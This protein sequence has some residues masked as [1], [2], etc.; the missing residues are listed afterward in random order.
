MAT[1]VQSKKI[2]VSGGVSQA[3]TFDNTVTTGN[4]I[5]VEV[6]SWGNQANGCSD[7]KSN[8]YS[9]QAAAQS[10]SV[11]SY[12]RIY[13][14]TASTAGSSFQVTV[15]WPGASDATVIIAE[16]SG[17]GSIECANSANG[18]GTSVSV[19][20]NGA[21]TSA[22]DTL[23]G[24]MAHDADGT[25]ALTEGYTLIEEAEDNHNSAAGN[26]QYRNLS[27][28]GT[29]S[30][31]WTIDTSA[32]WNASLIA[33]K[34]PTTPVPNA[35]TLNSASGGNTQVALSWTPPSSGSTPSGYKVRRGTSTG[36]YGT[37]I[38]VG[39]VTAYT[40]TGL[41]NGTQYF[42]VI[43]GYNASG[44]GANS[45]ELN[46]T[47][48]TGTPSAPTL[49]TAT[50]GNAQV[51]LTW[52]S[53]AGA[54]GYKIKYGTST[55]SHPTTIDVS[56]VTSYL[57]S[58]IGNGTPY[59]FV[60]VAYNASGDSAD[61]NELSATPQSG[62]TPNAPVFNSLVGTT[63]QL[64]ATW[65]V[66]PNAT[67]YKVKRGTTSGVYTTTTDVGN[68]TT[69]NITGLTNGTR[70]FVAVTA[71]NGVGDGGTSNEL[72][73]QPAATSFIKSKYND[74]ASGDILLFEQL[75]EIEAM[76]AGTHP[77]PDSGKI[78]KSVTVNGVNGYE[79]AVTRNVDGTGKN[80]WPA[81][82]AYVNTGQAGSGFIDQYSYTSVS[83]RPFEFICDGTTQLDPMGVDFTVLTG[84]SS[85]MYFGVANTKWDGL[86]LNITTP[87]VYTTATI[88]YEYWNGA[89]VTLTST[90][91]ATNASNV[92]VTADLKTVSRHSVV[93]TA[94]SDW[95]TTTIVGQAAYWIR[96]RVSAASG[97]T[98]NP[99]HGG[100]KWATRGKRQYG[101]SIAFM[102]RNSSTW[103]DF[104][105]RAT[106]GNLEGYYDYGTA[107][108]GIAAG[109]YTGAWLAADEINGIR[110]MQG[111]NQKGIIR[112][113]GTWTFTGNGSQYIDWNNTTLTVAG[114]INIIGG[115][116]WSNLTGLSGAI[117]TAGTTATWSGVSSIPSRI[118]YDTTPTGSGLFLSSTG[119]GFYN[120]S[121][122]RTYM[123]ASGQFFF[124]GAGGA[125]L[126]WD[127][128]ALAGYDNTP[129]LQWS[130]DATTGAIKAGGGKVRIDA[131][132]ITTI[133]TG[134]TIV[135]KAFIQFRDYADTS[136]A[137]SIG[138]VSYFGAPA[139]ATRMEL[140][141]PG[142]YLDG[143]NAYITIGV[144]TTTIGLNGTIV[145]IS[146]DASIGGN[147]TTYGDVSLKSGTLQVTNAVGVLRSPINTTTKA[148][149]V[150][151]G[152]SA[153]G[154]NAGFTAA[155]RDFTG[156][157]V[158][159]ANG[160]TWWVYGNGA[161]RIAVDG[162]GVA[163]KSSPGT[164]WANLSDARVKEVD[165][166][167]K[168]GLA[169]ILKVRPVVFRYNGKGG[170]IND[171]KRNVGV[172]AQEIREVFPATVFDA[173][174]LAADD[175]IKDLLAF[176]SSE[177]MWA[178]VNAIKELSGEVERL[179]IKTL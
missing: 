67:G 61:S 125:S 134:D 52:T 24:V 82:S 13:T 152:I 112:T 124:Y 138:F 175:E 105:A 26:A 165:A 73:A 9:P 22:T 107:A 158:M 121:A 3:L 93:F 151:G 156:D 21:T 19:S 118:A 90:V 108:Y 153:E 95:A 85:A 18:T 172:I 92:A 76:T 36:S 46:A 155:S 150:N 74:I 77:S 8:T 62:N 71:Y 60:A 63:T 139:G 111:T 23:T 30:L 109:D 44:D 89:W 160:N 161:N 88:V 1:K 163:Y 87:A 106:V 116:G 25:H 59:F 173:D 144:G 41:S 103:N 149:A 145:G 98:Q 65:S 148:L 83:S 114:T 81:G 17:V 126:Q 91:S 99:K 137:A 178:L 66:V 169:E 143:T 14:A 50:A 130:T 68:V 34:P 120:G 20:T 72:N 51:A 69:Y 58:G 15:T 157:W 39:N 49:S 35:P 32:N 122:W 166:P 101:S 131:N 12:S 48:A 133:A 28:T 54:T 179:K 6:A 86:F 135:N 123:N 159:Y 140:H 37:T 164:A 27:S 171:G 29:F 78:Y 47:P 162:N 45:N 57:V 154:S 33:L 129:A 38:D 5:V 117:T 167:Y 10:G 132:G 84:S 42:F 97:W 110:M 70:Y 102:R 2:Q 16:W 55:G 136:T 53:S 174:R 79:F 127:G 100:G 141:G 170:T 80:T 56:N 115:S 177:I 147:L 31:T 176:D 7:N 142:I 168:S 94:P 113:N 119:M 96:M 11:T 40:N 4:T 64:T 146:N 104:S 43:A 128:N 75:F